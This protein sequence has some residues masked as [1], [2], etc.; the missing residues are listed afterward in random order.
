MLALPHMRLAWIVVRGDETVC[1]EACKRLEMIADTFLS[2]GTP[3]QNACADLLPGRGAIQTQIQKRLENNLAYLRK[4]ESET[5]RL[6]LYRPEGGWY[7][8]LRLHNVR[9]E[10]AFA[11]KLLR[12]KGVM[13]HPGYFYDFEEGAHAVLS[14]LTPEDAWR[15]GVN[16]LADEMR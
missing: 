7:A 3:V 10:E 12:E 2:V 6:E 14:L 13:I 15:T 1:G 5:P 8:I 4:T 16:A 9:D 11:L